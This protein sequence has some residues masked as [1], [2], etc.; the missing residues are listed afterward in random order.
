MKTF[1]TVNSEYICSE[2]TISNKK[3]VC[4]SVYRP[5]FQENLELFFEK[6]SPCLSKA[7][8]TY[9]NF[10]VI[11]DFNID[12]GTKGREYEKF[13]DFCS[14]FN[15]SNL[16]KTETCFSKNHKSTISQNRQ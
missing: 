6:L 15:L 14:L 8:E 10:I 7:S 9:G 1:E 13:E 2:L 4:F 11:G 12:I 3:W 5:P 16:I